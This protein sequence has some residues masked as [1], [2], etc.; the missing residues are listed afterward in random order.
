MADIQL[1]KFKTICQRIGLNI[2]DG[3][4]WSWD[5]KFGHALVVFAKEDLE[6]ILLPIALE[7]EQKL[8]FATIDGSAAMISEFVHSGFGL[9]PGQDFFMAQDPDRRDL[10]LY[11]TCWPWGDGDNFSLRVGIFSSQ[12][13]LI[14]PRQIRACLTEWLP[15]STPTLP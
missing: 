15:I 12:S 14:S 1:E 6:L 11:A 10:I 4:Q 8:D 5:E 3:C 9:M 2:P 7:F 13:D